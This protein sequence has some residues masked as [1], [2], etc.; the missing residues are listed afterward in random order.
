MLSVHGYY[1]IT[2]SINEDT[3]TARQ[4]PVQKGDESGI[5]S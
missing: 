1:L 2:R 3:N 4:V 5:N